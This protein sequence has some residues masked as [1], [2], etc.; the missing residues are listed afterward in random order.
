MAATDHDGAMKAKPREFIYSGSARTFAWYEV[1]DTD[2]FL[3]ACG[4][5][6]TVGKLIIEEFRELVDGSCPQC[7]RMLM[8]RSFPANEP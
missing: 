1:D 6:G 7:D 3:C 2:R 8:I 5:S 4:W